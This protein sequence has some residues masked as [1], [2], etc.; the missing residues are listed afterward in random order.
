MTL[1]G[2][3][4][5]TGI[6]RHASVLLATSNPTRT[7]PVRRGKWILEALLDDAPP[8]PP[9]GIPNLPDTDHLE[10]G[11]TLRQIMEQHRADPN[12]SSC[13]LRMDAMGFALEGFDAVGRHRTELSNGMPIDDLGELPDGTLLDGA[14]GLRDELLERRTFERFQRSLLKNM[15]T[16]ALG[17]GIDD[18]DAATL[19][20]LV[21]RLGN[22]PSLRRMVEEIIESRAFL[23]RFDSPDAMMKE[24]GDP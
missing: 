2:A 17:R 23:Y 21:D 9:P 24:R 1:E 18:R 7:S 16:Y 14:L 20:R 22:D 8:P 3:H 19:D 11:A 13:H 15:M 4:Q 10:G 6:L 12:C 5:S